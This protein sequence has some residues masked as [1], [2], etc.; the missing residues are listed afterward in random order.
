MTT[1]LLNII[2]ERSGRLYDGDYD[3]VAPLSALG[4][5]YGVSILIVHH[6]RKQ[7]SDDAFDTISGSTGL[8]G[9]VDGLMVLQRAKGG[10]AGAELHIT[11]R[12]F[13]EQSLALQWD[14]ET[15]S[16]MV[17]GGAAEFTIGKERREILDLLKIHGSLKP[18]QISEKLGRNPGADRRLLA[19][20]AQDGLLLNDGKGS[21]SISHHTDNTGN[22]VTGLDSESE[23]PLLE[24]IETNFD[25]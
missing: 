6:T 5:K 17:L 24:N 14:A 11:G 1:W 18:A 7:A 13:E 21:Y 25:F 16:W 4:L 15:W 3:A 8:T 19:K 23:F 10:Q 20:M 12:D 22:R 9:A 2:A